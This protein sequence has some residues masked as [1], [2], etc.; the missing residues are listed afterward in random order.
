MYHQNVNTLRKDWKGFSFADGSYLLHV[1]S[2]HI[3]EGQK[4]LVKYLSSPE[5]NEQ[6]N[7]AFK[8][9]EAQLPRE[10]ARQKDE[11]K[12]KAIAL[13]VEQSC[14]LRCTYCY[15][16][17]GDYGKSSTITYDTSIKAVKSLSEGSKFFHISF[18]GGEPL[19]NFKI[20]QDVVEWCEKQ[21]ST[22]Y[23]YALTTNATLLN[24]SHLDFFKKHHF[25]IT[26][27]YDGKKIQEKQR[28]NM[29]YKTNADKLVRTKLNRYR[30]ELKKLDQFKIRSTIAKDNLENVKEGLSTNLD[31]YPYKMSFSRV[32]S[33]EEKHKYSL[34]DIKKITIALNE[35]V[36][37]YLTTQQYNKILRFGNIGGFIRS[38]HN[39]AIHQKACGA[40]ITYLSVSTTGKYY[41][42]HRFTEDN[43]ESVGDIE[44]GLNI[45]KLESYRDARLIKEEPCNS[46]WMRQWCA[47]GCFHENKIAN[48]N[49]F[50]PD[51]LFCTLQDTEISLAMKAYTTILKKA[52]HLLER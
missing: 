46:C 27:S 5:N 38:L 17:E 20:V 28:L 24:K 35:M 39:G 34:D 43:S 44:S 29:D 31:D 14:N 21:E 4:E 3:I 33:D 52:P 40:G 23:S 45:K 36:E 13:N 32:A 49:T 7:T 41:L 15:A 51:P 6:L 50:K 47:G 42:C 10:P 19:L 1:P 18:F 22:K 16:G 12:I 26:L 25:A 9:L 8:E 48:K 30:E 2:S 37:E 11:I